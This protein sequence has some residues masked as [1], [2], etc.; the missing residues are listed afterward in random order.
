MYLN[1]D[2]LTCGIS[3][4]AL[5]GEIL[6]YFCKWRTMIIMLIAQAEEAISCSCCCVKRSNNKQRAQSPTIAGWHSERYDVGVWL[7]HLVEI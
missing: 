6:D 4:N 5:C 2:V 1:L 3:H 7:K